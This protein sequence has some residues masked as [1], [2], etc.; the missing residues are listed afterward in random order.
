MWTHTQNERNYNYRNRR[1][2]S[3]NRTSTLLRRTTTAQETTSGVPDPRNTPPYR[4]RRAPAL[5]IG[6]GV[7]LH[8]TLR[9]P[10]RKEIPT[11][12]LR[13]GRPP[14]KIASMP[15]A[16]SYLKYGYHRRPRE[17]NAPELRGRFQKWTPHYLPPIYTEY[18]TKLRT[19]AGA[20]WATHQSAHV[21]APQIFHHDDTTGARPTGTTN[22][23]T[24]PRDTS[25]QTHAQMRR[26]AANKVH[27]ESENDE[28]DNAVQH[29]V[30]RPWV[31]GRLPVHRGWARTND[32][33]SEAR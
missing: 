17:Q 2:A 25:R 4:S 18:G 26:R 27:D 9:R 20:H 12:L 16:A 6:R 1:D 22:G 21:G 28:A 24:A 3:S 29:P 15:G 13:G 30:R 33:F 11:P 10:T 14:P 19:N 5:C 7:G 32:H 8:L 31:I 23:P